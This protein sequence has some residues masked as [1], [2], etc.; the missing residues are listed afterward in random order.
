MNIENATGQAATPDATYKIMD[1]ALEYE[2]VTQPDIASRIATE[3]QN[4]AL[5]YDRILRHRQIRLNKSDTTWNCSFNAPCKS[6]KGILDLFEGE[7]LYIGDMSKFYNLKIQKV[8]VIVQ[9][10]PNQL[11]A[12]GMRSFEQYDEICKYFAEGKQR[13]TNANEVQKQNLKRIR[14]NHFANREESRN[15][16]CKVSLN[17]R[18]PHHGCSIEH[19]EWSVCFYLI[20]GK[21]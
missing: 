14:R 9:G 13:N 11:H 2:I 12:Q 8:Y 10:K 3:Y 4:M 19:S 15:I 7:Q 16:I 17:L 5:Q 18:L 1:I 20:L 21:Y 6:L